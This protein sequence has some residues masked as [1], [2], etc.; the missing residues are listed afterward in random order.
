MAQFDWDLRDTSREDTITQRDCSVFSEYSSDT[1]PKLFV[2]SVVEFAALSA[3]SSK[4]SCRY[5]S[6]SS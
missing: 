6:P 1:A 3:G 2:Y 4:H 5:L